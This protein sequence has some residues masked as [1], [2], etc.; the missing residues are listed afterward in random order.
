MTEFNRIIKDQGPSKQEQF[1][2]MWHL[3]GVGEFVD[4]TQYSDRLE[5]FLKQVRAHTKEPLL[6]VHLNTEFKQDMIR[7]PIV[8]IA[9]QFR[10]GIA[11]EPHMLSFENVISDVSASIN[12]DHNHHTEAIGV[13]WYELR[14]SFMTGWSSWNPFLRGWSTD[15]PR[16]PEV[17]R[18]PCFQLIV[19][20]EAIAEWMQGYQNPG[21]SSEELEQM[22]LALGIDPI[23]LTVKTPATLSIAAIRSLLENRMA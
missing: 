6:T 11:V 15:C 23:T 17:L 7:H 10:L 8:N 22:C 12:A 19:G 16:D 18:A 9:P 20:R 21:L 2:H 1:N 3:R 5:D 4:A 13:G 14:D